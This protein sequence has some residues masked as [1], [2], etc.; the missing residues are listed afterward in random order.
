M[1]QE[2]VIRKR[3]R[4]RN[5]VCDTFRIAEP[6][7]VFTLETCD[8]I[9]GVIKDSK[10]LIVAV[11]TVNA[12]TTIVSKKGNYNICLNGEGVGTIYAEWKQGGGGGEECCEELRQKDA[13][14][15]SQIDN[16]RSRVV[17]LET[18]VNNIINGTL[19]T[20][21]C[22]ELENELDS[23]RERVRR[24]EEGGGGGGECC[25][26]LRT[27]IGNIK[28]RLTIVENKLNG[29]NFLATY[30]T[31]TA[32]E[33]LAHANSGNEPFAPF[34]V[35]RGNDY[36]VVTTISK[37]AD[38]KVNIRAISSAGGEFYVYTYTIT[39][40]TWSTA[41]YGLQGKLTAGD[42]ITINNG[43]I[44]ATGGGGGLPA[45]FAINAGTNVQVSKNG[46]AYTISATD[47][48]PDVD[49]AYVDQQIAANKVTL[50]EG[51]NVTITQSGNNYTI[52]ASGGGGSLPA[53]FNIVGG[54]NTQVSKSG[55]VYTISATDTN[56]ETVLTA[57]DN[58]SIT[59]SGTDGNHNYRIDVGDAEPDDYMVYS[60]NP[61]IIITAMGNDQEENI[62]LYDASIAG[63][64]ADNNQLSDFETGT[65]KIEIKGTSLPKGQLTQFAT[66]GAGIYYSNGILS[67]N[68]GTNVKTI[69]KVV[70]GSTVAAA[71]VTII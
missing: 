57:G 47:T 38:N 36:H 39:D 18:Q 24:L 67:Y 25:D 32:Q 22:E 59:D 1:A 63:A 28:D 48:V 27:E 16:I 43:V 8:E 65:D 42:N 35:K 34:L 44:S 71:D 61:N 52:S 9:E 7:Y 69:V 13:E 46:N 41:T 56:T 3:S 62:F 17:T 33:I 50:T 64:T 2:I 55:N 29:M 68:D 19:P 11:L 4:D 5:Q 53:D 12:P 49:K 60:K 45:D 31:T 15:Q 40:G 21:C 66:Q 70:D 30:N 37:L 23:L 6:S 20:G 10:G 14:L 58:V 26:E 51:T 54:T